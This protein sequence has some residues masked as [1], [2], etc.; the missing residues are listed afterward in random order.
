MGAEIIA[1]ALGVLL[2]GF[3]K[4]TI[5]GV[6]AGTTIFT[7]LKY[8]DISKH[9]TV[10][11]ETFLAM[12][13][14][15]NSDFVDSLGKQSGLIAD[16]ARQTDVETIP[17]GLQDVANGNKLWAANGGQTYTLTDEDAKSYLD[18]CVPVALK[19]LS[20]AARA[21]YDALKAAAASFS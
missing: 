13:G 8:Y 12:L 21:D 4:W 11:P 20:P 2:P 17:W 14:I 10:F 19:S 7:A 16:V 3:E 5:D 18:Q 15:V 6:F 9:M 1:K